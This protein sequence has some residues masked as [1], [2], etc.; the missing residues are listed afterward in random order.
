M[1]SRLCTL[2]L[3]ALTLC[4]CSGRGPQPA[5]TPSP[6]AGRAELISGAHATATA[7]ISQ[8]S[9]ADPPRGPGAP[10]TPTPTTV[11]SPTVTPSTSL[12]YVD[13]SRYGRAGSPLRGR[14]SAGAPVRQIVPN[15][16]AVIAVAMPIEGADGRSWYRVRY[17]G[18]WGYMPAEVLS[19]APP[20][21]PKP[22][23]TPAQPPDG[24]VRASFPIYPATA[25]LDWYRLEELLPGSYR[26]EHL[27]VRYR[28]GTFAA[29]HVSE[30]AQAAQEGLAHAERL[31][32]VRLAGDVTFYLAYAPFP[33][34][35]PGLRGY[36]RARDRAIFQ[37]YD[38]VGTPLERQYLS[39]HELTHQLA[40]DGIGPSSSVML[41]EG[42]AM[43]ASEEY[44]LRDGQVSLD[45]FARAALAT[46]TLIPLEQ[47]AS[48][49]VR[50]MGRLLR[51]HPYD[52]AGSF[53]GYLV[54]T[55]GLAKFK[56]VYV[57]GDYL[58]TYGKPLAQLDQEWRRYL[59]SGRAQGPF[60]PD[61][62]RYIESV[63]EVQAR[64]E[65]LFEA[66][67]R[68]Q[69]IS[70]RAYLLLD[71]ARVEADRGQLEGCRRLLG[72][73]DELWDG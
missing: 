14:P 58:G 40:S 10:P 64:Y 1:T 61:P 54:R 27:V 66:L 49:R 55:Y 41:S 38:G 57:S 35:D 69:P 30:F 29:T 12:L 11:P 32:G 7:I 70:R 50:F 73:F 26:T 20:P 34:P 45:G 60:A 31:L 23:P 16:R 2:L 25:D 62:E 72:E 47:L 39:T 22:T 65:E 9:K 42:L 33:N 71:Q 28:P 6:M 56:Q 37:L 5:P 19:I 51:R 59:I 18:R 52:E 67:G 68:G 24:E 48:G 53:V 4:G 43:Y 3:L 15:G 44:L 63:G 17:M 36:S 21:T 46:G 13:A 8:A